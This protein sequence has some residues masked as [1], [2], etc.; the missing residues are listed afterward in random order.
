MPPKPTDDLETFLMRQNLSTLVGILIEL[1]NGHEA[2][3]ARLARLRLADRPDKLAAG[4]SKTLTAWRRSSKFFTYREAGEFGRMLEA[5]LFQVHRE[6][7]PKDPAA[8]LA[9][10]ESF[11]EADGAFFEHADDSDG[12][13]GDAVRAACRHWLQAATR[14]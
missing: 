2:V 6:L 3:Q 1:A 8:A 13:I 14:C 11:I 5:W 10:F 9:L 12:C 4:F 7:L